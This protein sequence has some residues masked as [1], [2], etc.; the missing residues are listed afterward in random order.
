MKW[1]TA[2]QQVPA[3]QHNARCGHLYAR[4]EQFEAYQLPGHPDYEPP[5]CEWFVEPDDE[6]KS[7]RR[8]LVT[9]H[10]STVDAAK[11]AVTAAF[12]KLIAAMQASLQ[13]EDPR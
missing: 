2:T 10:A 6:D 5:K 8:A 7:Y 9:G 13:E 1:E 4:I 11:E 3:D 12:V